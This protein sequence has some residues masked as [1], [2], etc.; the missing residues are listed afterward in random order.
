MK[1]RNIVMSAA[2]TA[3]LLGGTAATAY[4]QNTFD[5]QFAGY[6]VWRPEKY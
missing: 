5:M 4:G 2:T 3:M 1:F 6:P